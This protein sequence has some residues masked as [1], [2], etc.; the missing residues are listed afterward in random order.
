MEI[1]LSIFVLFCI[2]II[3][4]LF[5]SFFSLANYRIPKHEDITHTRSYC[6][7]CKHKL[8][9]FDLIPVWSFVF[10]LGKCRYCKEKISPRYI[11]LEVFNGIFFVIVYIIVFYLTKNPMNTLA[12][13][14]IFYIFY[15]FIFV[16]IGSRVMKIKQEK[17]N[18]KGVYVVELVI[19]FVI[20]LI[21]VS[22][23]LI[24]SRNYSYNLFLKVNEAEIV[25]ATIDKMENLKRTY[26][27]ANFNTITSVEN[28]T[29]TSNGITYSFNLK[30]TD[31]K[32]QK[33][34]KYDLI[35]T[36]NLTLTRNVNGKDI[37]YNISD[38]VINYSL[39]NTLLEGE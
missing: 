35:K 28:G 27:T 29:F 30:V 33:N 31:Y 5:G 25:N 32:Q 14:L 17:N 15:A 21:L 24:I 18:K 3:G 1:F 23:C 37:S 4:T 6:P 7:K 16:I 19:A 10:C 39:L 26:S 34:V 13:C 20:F 8:S 9:F 38:Y 12:I 2:F 22:S 11:L 36:L